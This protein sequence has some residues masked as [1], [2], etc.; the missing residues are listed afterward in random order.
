MRTGTERRLATLETAD[1][2]PP[3]VFVVI[4]D[5]TADLVLPDDYRRDVDTL[6]EIVGTDPDRD[7]L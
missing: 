6:I 1:A 4:H 5:S 7:E 3:R 2:P